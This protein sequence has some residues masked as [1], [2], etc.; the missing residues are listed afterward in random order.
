MFY[1]WDLWIAHHF[2][3]TMSWNMQVCSS[4]FYSDDN[5]GKLESHLPRHRLQWLP[6]WWGASLM[7]QKW[8]DS[9]PSAPHP[10]QKACGLIELM[11]F[12]VG[13]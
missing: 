4:R 1:Y 7:I 9:L 6:L 13:L 2:Y 8:W 3:F 12:L 10:S 5:G 11:A